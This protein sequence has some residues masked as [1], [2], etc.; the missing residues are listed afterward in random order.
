MTNDNTTNLAM[1]SRYRASELCEILAATFPALSILPF[2]DHWLSR[3]FLSLLV[4]APLFLLAVWARL[5][6]AALETRAN[7]EKKSALQVVTAQRLKTLEA[8]DVGKDVLD[9]L[10]VRIGES[11]QPAEKFIAWLEET[12]GRERAQEKLDVI[13]RYTRLETKEPSGGE[14]RVTHGIAGTG[15]S[16]LGAPSPASL[17]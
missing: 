3:L 17:Q 6:G 7:H 13:L 8:V 4:A 9:A 11:P 2:T 12:L 14:E 16:S 10:N 15:P 5:L 1:V